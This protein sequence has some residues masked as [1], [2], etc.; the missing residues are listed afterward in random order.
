VDRVKLQID[1]AHSR[2][3]VRG[4]PVTIKVPLGAK[5]VQLRLTHI[6]PEK[7][8]SFAKICDV[9]FNGRPA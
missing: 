5:L 6:D 9:F 2:R 7:L 1:A 8:D 4:E 3:L